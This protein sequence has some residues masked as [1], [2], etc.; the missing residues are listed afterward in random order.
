M[1]GPSVDFRVADCFKPLPAPSADLVTLGGLALSMFSL[2]EGRDLLANLRGSVKSGGYPYFDY[3]PSLREDVLWNE[4]IAL[5]ALRGGES[6][7]GFVLTETRCIPQL[8]RQES[9][10]YLEFNE[11]D[12]GA[13]VREFATG[14]LHILDPEAV[15]GVVSD[16]GLRVVLSETYDPFA[17]LVGA[18]GRPGWPICRVLAEAA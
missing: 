1:R 2:S 14:V 7:P 9:H 17:G 11:A 4:T 16:A 15:S 3:L 18:L 8:A 13:L 6:V 10:F 12:S 5:P